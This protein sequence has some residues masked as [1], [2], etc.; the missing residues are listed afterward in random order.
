MFDLDCNKLYIL[1]GINAAA[2]AVAKEAADGHLTP[3]AVFEKAGW[4]FAFVNSLLT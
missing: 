3:E 2:A 1:T 4:Y